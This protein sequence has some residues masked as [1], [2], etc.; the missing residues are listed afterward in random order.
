[1]GFV[2]SFVKQSWAIAALADATNLTSGKY[3][4]VQGDTTTRMLRITEVLV[5][6]EA[7]AAAIAAMVLARDSTAGGT[8]SLSSGCTVAGL[9]SG[10]PTTRLASTVFDTATTPPQRASALHLLELSM[11]AFGGIIRWVAAPG[12]EIYQVGNAVNVGGTSLSAFTGSGT[13]TVSSH[14]HYEEL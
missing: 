7:S 14:I 3:Q 10:A 12:S 6:G 9:S 8:L 11:N 13:P 1:M 4:A 5:G 2:Y